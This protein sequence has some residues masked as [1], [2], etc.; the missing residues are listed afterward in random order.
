LQLFFTVGVPI[1][2]VLFMIMWHA[3]RPRRVARV[4]SRQQLT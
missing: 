2:T 3:V 1:L 4:Q